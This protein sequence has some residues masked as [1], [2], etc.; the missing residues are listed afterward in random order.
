MAQVLVNLLSNASKYSPVGTDVELQRRR[1]GR[2]VAGD[3]G[4]SRAGTERR[5][6]GR[7]SSSAA[8]GAAAKD[9]TQYGVGLGLLV[10]K[11]IVAGHGGEVGVL[12]AGWRRLAL[13]VHAAGRR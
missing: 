10:V 9:N 1:G 5:P 12:S 2:G 3:G 6:S 7:R 8:C 11:A 4:R 13:L